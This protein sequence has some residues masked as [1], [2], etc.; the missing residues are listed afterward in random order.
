M[1]LPCG[2]R[3]SAA[4][5]ITTAAGTGSAGNTTSTTAAWREIKKYLKTTLRNN[6][7]ILSNVLSSQSD[8][9]D[10]NRASVYP[11][12]AAA[13][14]PF[15]SE[16]SLR[17]FDLLRMDPSDIHATDSSSPRA[18]KSSGSSHG[19]RFGGG[20]DLI[21]VDEPDRVHQYLA[22]F[23]PACMKF[24]QKEAKSL[25]EIWKY[26]LQQNKGVA[27]D[28][29]QMREILRSEY[30]LVESLAPVDFPLGPQHSAVGVASGAAKAPGKL[31]KTRRGS[32][33]SSDASQS[34]GTDSDVDPSN[35]AGQDREGQQHPPRA[36]FDG[37]YVV[38]AACDAQLGYFRDQS[39]GYEVR[40]SRLQ[41]SGG[42][43]DTSQAAKL[44]G[45]TSSAAGASALCGCVH[46]G[47]RPLTAADV[48][49]C[50]EDGCLS[51]HFL[52]Y[53]IDHSTPEDAPRAAT[54]APKAR[55]G[56]VPGA[57]AKT[58][59]AVSGE[60]Y[61]W[62][63]ATRATVPGAT[64]ETSG[65]QSPAARGARSQF[66]TVKTPAAAPAMSQQSLSLSQLMFGS[67]HVPPTSQKQSQGASQSQ[68]FAEEED[69][70]LDVTDN[71][72][73]VLNNNW[74]RAVGST[75]F[76]DT[77]L[78]SLLQARR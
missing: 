37:L 16:D 7:L 14:P 53:R 15:V 66:S 65:L 75:S 58:S 17:G 70:G 49:L 25:W 4:A 59:T 21:M 46:S 1:C 48:P 78:S 56:M 9:A 18:S 74:N 8:P 67:Q 42:I 34:D 32:L 68:A 6:G 31:K 12:G 39:K 60:P 38:D 27:V 26:A 33:S 35:P 24:L 29:V 54:K 61:Y 71:M 55:P 63:G 76:V 72:M 69:L 19:D 43:G 41:R 73:A 40:L 2:I 28:L 51:P 22:K 30:K 13:F 62:G 20:G 23:R 36:T 11:A 10:V 44:S 77:A 45:K 47:R 50:G 52:L 64:Q 5:S 3:C 57:A